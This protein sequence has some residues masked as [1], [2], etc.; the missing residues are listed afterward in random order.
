[1][2]AVAGSLRPAERRL[3]TGEAWSVSGIVLWELAKRAELGRIAL[4]LQ[5]PDVIRVLSK[6]YVWPITRE[7]PYQ[8]T[9][10]DVRGDPADELIAA[11]SV[12]HKVPLVT[13]DAGLRRSKVVPIARGRY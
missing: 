1:M 9:Q 5:D 6:I 11:T 8:S 7:I 12:V 10:L 2:Y 3:L 13:R 4:D